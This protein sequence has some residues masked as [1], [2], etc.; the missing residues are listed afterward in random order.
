MS[1]WSGWAGAGVSLISLGFSVYATLG[2]RRARKEAKEAREQAAIDRLANQHD[3]RRSQLDPWGIETNLAGIRRS[4]AEWRDLSAQQL[5]ALPRNTQRW[6][7]VRDLAEAANAFGRSTDD[8]A[9]HHTGPDGNI[10]VTGDDNTTV[11][12]ALD[13][14][15]RNTSDIIN[16]LVKSG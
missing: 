8:I 11:A 10:P 15:Q 13:Q 3:I 9:Q 4:V 5:D 12:A 14:F 1:D 16:K 6:F 7:L 2:A